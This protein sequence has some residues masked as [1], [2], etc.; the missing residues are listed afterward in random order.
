MW[1]PFVSWVVGWAWVPVPAPPPPILYPKIPIAPRAYWTLGWRARGGRGYRR[2]SLNPLPL[3]RP[4][5]I[6]PSEGITIPNTKPALAP[7]HPHPGHGQR[8]KK[9]VVRMGVGRG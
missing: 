6:V 7:T 8:P 9:S 5:K 3:A 2:V 1:V 4:E